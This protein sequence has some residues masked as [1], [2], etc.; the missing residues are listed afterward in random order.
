MLEFDPD[1]RRKLA[2][3]K[4]R[5]V[6]ERAL[7]LRAGIIG[8]LSSCLCSFPV[9]LHETSSQHHA[10]C[11]AHHIIESAKRAAEASCR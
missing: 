1:L 8:A 9:E 6:M 11:P 10:T 4:P 3:G 7:R 2:A 5:E